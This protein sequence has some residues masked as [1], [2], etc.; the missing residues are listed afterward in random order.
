[1]TQ[2]PTAPA[3]LLTLGDVNYSLRFD[4]EAIAA[5]EELTGRALLTGLS[6][7][8]I[9]TPTINLVRAMLYASLLPDWPTITFDQAKALV[10]L[11]TMTDIWV[12]ILEAWS[13][14]MAEPDEAETE[15]PTPA[16]S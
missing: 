16:Q 3:V 12:K 8:D 14:G 4:F 5:A 10:N 2:N 11:K 1:M 15:T 6:K 7:Q 9:T 13:S